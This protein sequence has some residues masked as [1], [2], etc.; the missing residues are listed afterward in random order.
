[1][2]NLQRNQWIGGTLKSANRLRQ[3]VAVFAK[4]GFQNIV[5]ELELGKYFFL[6]KFSGSS[7]EQS[8]T[9]AERLRM[10]LESLG[11]TWIKFGQMLASRPDLVPETFMS[12]LKKLQAQ[13]PAM[14]FE[15]VQRI[16]S[17]E[18]ERPVSEIYR[19]IEPIPLGAAS[20][21]QVHKATLHT[22][23]EVVLK[24]QRPNLEEA[25][26]DDLQVLY[27]LSLLLEKYRPELRV[28][29]LSSM[30]EEFASAIE[31]E[32]DF[33]IEANNMDRFRKN[34]FADPHVVIPK[35]YNDLSTSKVLVQEELKGKNLN[36]PEAFNQKGI[37]PHD[38][39]QIGIRAFFKMIFKDGVFHAD[40]HEGNIFVL[41]HQQIGLIDFGM[42]G[43][44]SQKSRDS[45][46]GIMMSIGNEDYEQL[47]FEFL[48]LS[49]YSYDC[50]VDAF[51]HEIQ[52]LFAP[53]HGLSFANFQIGKLLL[54]ATRVAGKHGISLPSDLM[55]LFKSILTIEGMGRSLGEDFDL[56]SFSNEFAVEVIKSKYNFDRLAKNLGMITKDSAALLTGLP[57]HARQ[58]L[59][60][61]N[62]PNFHWKLQVEEMHELKRGVEK[63]S[64]IIFLGL[65]ISSMLISATGAMFIPN[66]TL[67]GGIPAISAILYGLATFT[68]FVAVYNYIRK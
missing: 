52:G 43:Y 45:I 55:L 39:I 33:Y 60:K 49:P 28:L 4:H 23:E 30:V 8:F 15:T 12:E 22:G 67:I 13:V 65:V 32:L 62:S 2:A 57:R 25:I 44:L 24:V 59:R 18:Y 54:D 47:A 1:M 19:E 50:D 63:G 21:A 34:F 36:D 31:Q 46:A 11:P 6:E 37:Y 48:E 26:N 38:V 16:L 29:N 64:N 68:G 51:T 14:P 56:L 3:I 40:L 7:M 53:Y 27:T 17:E 42:I 61:L 5:E 41:P 10:A 35:V 58:A 20:I 66:S 9:T